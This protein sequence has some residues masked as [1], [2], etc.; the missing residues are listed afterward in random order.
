MAVEWVKVVSDVGTGGVVGA[1]DQL[2]QN[3]DDK[4]EAEALAAGQKLGAMKRFGT[5]F[6]YGVPIVAILGSAMGWLKGDWATRL[7]TAGS[8]LA[9]REITHTVTKPKPAA[10]NQ[11]ERNREM[12]AARAAA[13]GGGGQRAALEF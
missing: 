8:Q 10:W 2:L 5:Y 6:N 4:R 9:G 1:A 13:L 3:Q 12:E 11:W 7:T